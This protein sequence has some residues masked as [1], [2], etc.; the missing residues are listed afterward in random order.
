M[1]S[2]PREVSFSPAEAS[3]FRQ[4]LTQMQAKIDAVNTMVRLACAHRGLEGNWQLKQDASGL[5][6]QD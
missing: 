4:A 2:Q 3:E 1:N 5:A 6:K